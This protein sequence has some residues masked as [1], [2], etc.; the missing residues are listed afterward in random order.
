MGGA[1]GAVRLREDHADQY[2]GRAG[3]AD[4]RPRDRGWRGPGQTFRKRPGALPSGETRFRL[5]AVPPGAVRE[6]HRARQADASAFATFWRRAAA[7]GD[8]ESLDQPAE[9]NFGR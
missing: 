9:T 6:R 5:S 8:C 1:D 2:S 4:V 7:C 3:Y